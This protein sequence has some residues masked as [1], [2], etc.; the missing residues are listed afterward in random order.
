MEGLYRALGSTGRDA[1]QPHYCDACFT[2]DYPIPLADLPDNDK[3]QLSLL[4]ERQLMPALPG[5]PLSRW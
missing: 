3:R 4:S 1:A 5:R 2:G